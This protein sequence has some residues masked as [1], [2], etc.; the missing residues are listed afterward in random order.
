MNC[1]FR[2]IFGYLSA[3]NFIDELSYFIIDHKLIQTC[4]CTDFLKYNFIFHPFFQGNL[5]L[6]ASLGYS[7]LVQ[8]HYQMT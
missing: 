5:C 2:W 7:V 6:S 8:S 1:T 4:L 3:V